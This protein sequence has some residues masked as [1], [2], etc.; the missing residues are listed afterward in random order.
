MNDQLELLL[1]WQR[2]KDSGFTG[3]AEAFADLLRKELAK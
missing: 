1:A 2:A 3:M